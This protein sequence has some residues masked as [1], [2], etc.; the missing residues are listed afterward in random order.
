LAV[1]SPSYAWGLSLDP[2]AARGLAHYIM[3]VCHDLNGETAQAIGE[4]QKSV[5]FNAK[6]AAP[7]LK[8]GAYY[9]RLDQMSK[10]T[11]QLKAAARISPQDPQTH[12]LLAL[13]YSSEHQ[14]DLA[15]SEY[16]I[17]LKST[18]QDDPVNTDAYLYLGQLYYAQGKYP[19][20][21]EQFLKIIHLNPADTSALCLLGSVYADANDN[22]KAIG[23]FRKVLQIE[24]D[25]SEA[26]NSLGYIYAEE[27]LHLDEAIKMVRKA[28]ENDPTNGAYYDSLGWALYKKG[29]YAESLAALKKAGT[30]I[31]DEIL[32]KHLTAVYKALKK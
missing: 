3:A 22:S 18:A 25:N 5:R 31:K 1:A 15:A 9:L 23:V 26:L 30:Y 24:P 28:I 19:Q 13:I 16:E 8:L 2:N 32:D 14:Y 27:G 6:E 7:R 20:A 12:Y 4:Y 10:A 17:V 11:D 21:I 29:S